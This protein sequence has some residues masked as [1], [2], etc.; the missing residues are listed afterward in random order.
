MLRKFTDVELPIAAR[1][2][3]AKPLFTKLAT[4]PLPAV[5]VETGQKTLEDA[6]DSVQPYMH[7]GINP[8]RVSPQYTFGIPE[9]PQFAGLH[10]DTLP[11]QHGQDTMPLTFHFTENGVAI[12]SMLRPGKHFMEM[13]SD[14]VEAQALS[15]TAR[16]NFLQ[17][18]VDE[19]YLQPTRFRCLSKTGTL[20]VFKS[21]QPLVHIFEDQ[22]PRRHSIAYDG[23]IVIHPNMGIRRRS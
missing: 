18:V 9:T 4:T 3:D 15:V 6:I 21:G 13:A 8:T 19:N 12:G 14:T 16:I 11:P 5:V 17:G 10:W 20:V 1:P 2:I 22:P 7:P 23:T